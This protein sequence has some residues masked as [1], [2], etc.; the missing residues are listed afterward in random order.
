M[1]RS[2]ATAFGP[3]A[4]SAAGARQN[5]DVEGIVGVE[6]AE[7]VRK[8]VSGGAID[9]VASVRAVDRNGGDCAID[10]EYNRVHLHPPG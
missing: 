10:L 6:P 8:G 7:R 5:R 9:G 1:P 3:G 4:K 2:V